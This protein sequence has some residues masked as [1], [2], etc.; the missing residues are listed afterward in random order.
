MNAEVTVAALMTAPRYECVAAR[1]GIENALKEIGIPLTISG[2]VFYTQC[3]QIM[4]ED[5]VSQQIDYALTID[6]DSVMTAAHIQRLLNIIEQEDHIDALA[7]IQP[8]RGKGRVLAARARETVVDWDGRPIEVTSAHFG[9]TVIDL[10]KLAKVPKPWFCGLPDE[11]GRWSDDRVD[12]DVSFWRAWEQSGNSIY[13][14]PG[15]RLGH[16]EEMVTVFDED[17]TLRHMYLKDWQKQ[18][19]TTVDC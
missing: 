18:K 9:L 8:M 7:A 11:H 4:L 15:C 5:V 6:F 3:M 14:D 17:L 19:E 13:I 12:P 2:G 1:N 16:L 10:K